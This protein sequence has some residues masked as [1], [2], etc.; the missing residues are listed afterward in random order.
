[1]KKVFRKIIAGAIFFGCVATAVSAGAYID[2]KASAEFEEDNTPIIILD[3]GH[4]EST[5]TEF[6]K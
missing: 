5:K 6:G 3:A 2:E 4:G 1:M